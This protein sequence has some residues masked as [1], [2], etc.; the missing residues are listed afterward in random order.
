MLTTTHARLARIKEARRREDRLHLL[1]GL[2]GM[3][4]VAAVFGTMLAVWLLD[5]M[6]GL[7]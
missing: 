4:V 2:A 5:A 1:I 6:G 3:A 7:P